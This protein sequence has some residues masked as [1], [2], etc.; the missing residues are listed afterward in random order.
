[1]RNSKSLLNLALDANAGEHTTLI[2]VLITFSAVSWL[3][4]HFFRPFC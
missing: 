1:M 2:P 4:I 3:V